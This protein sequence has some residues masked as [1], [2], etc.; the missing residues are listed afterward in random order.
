MEDRSGIY[1][2]TNAGEASWFDFAK[3]IFAQANARMGIPTPRLKPVA[4]SDFPRPAAR[5]FNS[6][7]SGNKLAEAFGVR[8]PRWEHAL[9]LVLETR[10]EGR[11]SG[12]P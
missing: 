4:T 11:S 5:P 3:E 8:P 7:L 12:K 6:R 2:L 1:N 9:E 10:S